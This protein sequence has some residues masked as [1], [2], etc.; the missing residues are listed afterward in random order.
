[1]DFLVTNAISHSHSRKQG[2]K[3][4]L[5]QRSSL[6]QRLGFGPI[7]A[8]RQHLTKHLIAQIDAQKWVLWLFGLC[9][10]R[11]APLFMAVLQNGDGIC[12][13]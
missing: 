2:V 6:Q 12:Q 11:H 10:W 13:A 5:K 3:F 7:S 1:M 9:L 8:F 4:P